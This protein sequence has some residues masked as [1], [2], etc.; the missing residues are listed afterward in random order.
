MRAHADL[1]R[2]D[3]RK[4]RRSSAGADCVEVAVVELPAAPVERAVRPAG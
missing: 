2:T 3:W 4:S 1:S